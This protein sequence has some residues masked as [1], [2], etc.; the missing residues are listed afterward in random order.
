MTKGSKKKSNTPSIHVGSL[1][2]CAE[3]RRFLNTRG[4]RVMPSALEQARCQ[5]KLQ[6]RITGGRG[7]RGQKPR[8]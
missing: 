4:D 2:A 6:R 5:R 7:K 3:G 1:R 8:R